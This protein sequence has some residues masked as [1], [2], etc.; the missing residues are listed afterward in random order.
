VAHP[1]RPPE[2]ALAQFGGMEVSMSSTALTGLQ[3][4]VEYLVSYPYGC[5]E[6][7]ASRLVPIFALSDI[8]PAF[9]VESLADKEKQRRYAEKGIRR[10]ISLQKHDGGFKFWSSSWRSYPYPS[11]Y[12]TWALLR[13]K[14]A[15]FDVP[16][17]V[18]RKASRY[19][20]RVLYG[21]YDRTWP[22]YYSRTVKV[23][24]GWLLTELRDADFISK[25]QKRRWNLK[26][27]LG[28]IYKA[29]AKLGVFAKAWLMTALFRLEKRSQ[30]VEELLR[31]I[32]NSAV[33]SPYGIH[34]T[35]GT[36]ESLRLLMHT[37]TRTDAIVLSSYMEVDPKNVI[38]P[39]IVRALM[40][41]RVKG[42]W[43]TTQAN[44]FVMESLAGYFRKYEKVEPEFKAHIWYGTGYGGSAEF[45]GRSME[46]VDREL[47]MSFLLAQGDKDLVLAK[48]GAGKLYYRLGLDYAPKSLRLPP[49]EQGFM[50]RRVYEPVEGADTV[51]KGK[52]GIWR[53]K[54]GSYVRVRLTVVVSDRRYFVA[55]NDPLPA[56]LE[57]VDLQLRTSASS[58]LSG[59]RRNKIY[60]FRSYY[61]FRGPSH[62]EMR[63]ERYVLFWDRLPAGV[64][65][66]TYLARATTIGRFVVPPLKAMEMYHPEVFGRNGTQIVEVVE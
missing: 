36:T 55:V 17:D 20:S 37:N 54:A 10:L 56:G 13:G 5:A 16:E 63:D 26:R 49:E 8:L 40:A 27:H 28:D 9:G 46:I 15:G 39:K 42:R 30:R 32:E 24:A 43:E 31:E 22:G 18:L 34:F 51:V 6:Q 33:Q 57:G 12:A 44:A 65:E 25:Y 41:A 66:Y 29:R 61:A 23:M 64:Y 58:R 35:E 38:V 2:E 62:K 14:Q 59:H 11:V 48:K 21:R 47:P 1:I 4:A 3:D 19:L 45:T 7:V 53:I 50:V 52:D 60:D